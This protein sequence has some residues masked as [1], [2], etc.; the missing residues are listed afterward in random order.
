LMIMFKLLTRL[1]N[2]WMA[3]AWRTDWGSLYK[4]LCEE[5]ARNI[6][7]VVCTV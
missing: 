5:M 6:H 3:K 7:R 2:K 1:L 4:K